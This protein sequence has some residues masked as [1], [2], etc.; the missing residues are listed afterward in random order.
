AALRLYAT[1]KALQG[2]T[3]PLDCEILLLS[4]DEFFE[5]D[6][7]VPKARRQSLLAKHLLRDGAH[8]VG[9]ESEL[10]HQFLERSRGAKGLHA[11][12]ATGLA[13]IAIPAEGRGLLN[14]Q[15]GPHR[16]RQNTVTIFL[17]L[18]IEDFP[19]RHR[20]DA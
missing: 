20:N 17:R 15:A 19:R 14:R 1:Q 9:L 12:H 5:L 4:V 13:N 6:F 2:Q 10:L 7:G 11:N 16:W 18:M 3:T 8:L